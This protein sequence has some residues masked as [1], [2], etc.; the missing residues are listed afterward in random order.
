MSRK[1]K[2]AEKIEKELASSDASNAISRGAAALNRYTSLR[3]KRSRKSILKGCAT[4]FGTTL[5]AVIIVAWIYISGINAS[6]RAGIDNALLNQLHVTEAGNPFYILLL[7]V[8]KDQ[9]RVNSKEYGTD[10]HAYRSDSIMLARVDPKNKKVTL[11]SIHRDTL[12]DMGK[13]G[14]QKINAAY[15]LGGASYA[16]EVISKFAGVPI[17]HYADIDF[18]NF[19]SVVD[20]IGGIDVNV[21][22]KVDDSKGTGQVVEAGQQTLNGQQALVL[23]RARHAYDA[24]GDGDMYR[25]AN[26]RMVIS[27]I[28]KKILQL[29]PVTMATVIA[30]LSGS[31][32]TDMDVNSII[33]LATS[34]R[35]LNAATDIYHGMEPTTSKYVNQTWYEICNTT[36]WKKMMQRVDQGLSPYESED[37]NPTKGLAGVTGGINNSPNGSGS[38]S[39]T[40]SGS[41][42]TTSSTTD[43]TEYSGS[44]HVLNAA[45]VTGLAGRISNSLSNQGFNAVADT[46][47]SNYS[48]TLIV[49]NGDHEA[50]ANAVNKALGGDIQVIKND[51]SYDTSYDVILIVGADKSNG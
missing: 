47:K 28:G 29:D 51:G 22:I 14:K 23:C 41:N 26:Q 16:T 34:L 44:V 38:S 35:G 42:N 1:T 49:Y 33:G 9:N 5:A 18:D 39:S 2:H 3:K 40:S 10:E 32:T 50:R 7:G 12:V 43:A 24:Y 20:T 46:A 11:V 21:P 36:A 8:D 31:V 6:L 15:A 25:A 19:V 4:V 48:N 30:K 27:A 37:D 45:G 13:N 17:S